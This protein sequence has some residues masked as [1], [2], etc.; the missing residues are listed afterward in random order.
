MSNLKAS[1]RAP[2]LIRSGRAVDTSPHHVH[3]LYDDSSPLDR[4]VQ[5]YSQ[6]I[7]EEFIFLKPL[8]SASV[9]EEARSL[10]YGRNEIFMNGK[11]MITLLIKSRYGL[12]EQQRITAYTTCRCCELFPDV[13]RHENF[14][15]F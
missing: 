13:F 4:L 2:P 7:P 9:S 3:G 10:R 12:C 8:K 6:G 11:I 15:N 1:V 5:R 14:S